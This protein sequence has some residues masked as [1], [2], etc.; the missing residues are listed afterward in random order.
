[1]KTLNGR[2]TPTQL[3]L[4]IFN[5]DFSMFR[6]ISLYV[7]LLL[8]AVWLGGFVFYFGVVVPTGGRIVGGTEQG[9][10]TQKV[11]DWLNLIGAASLVIFLAQA[12]LSKS[13]LLLA[14]WG[15]MLVCQI[16]LFLMH[17]QLDLLAD[18]KTMAISDSK[19]F[20]S[21]HE[22]YELVA[23]ALW[24]AGMVYLGGLVWS[25]GR[26]RAVSESDTKRV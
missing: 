24:I 10:V 22:T 23:T 4:R 5:S 12:L 7:T 20:G 14:T 26:V 25:M 6:A 17:W 13:R 16:T 2:T 8:W 11:T 3:Y 18:A 15:V 19:R 9:F 21:L 1:M